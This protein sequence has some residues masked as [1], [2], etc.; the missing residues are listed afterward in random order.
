MRASSDAR[1]GDANHPQYP[2]CRRPFRQLIPNAIALAAGRQHL[3]TQGGLAEQGVAGQDAAR[4]SDATQQD[5]RDR[6]LRFR[7]VGRGCDRLVGE[8]DAV[9]MTE[10]AEGVDRATVLGE[11]KPAP[12]RFA[13][14][15][16]ALGGGLGRRRRRVRAEATGQRGRQGIAIEAAKQALQRRLARRAP[17]RKAERSEHARL[18]PR[19]PFGYRQDR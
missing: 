6:Q 8:D 19:A 7:L 13:V 14:D 17:V 1:R 3:L 4:P 12:L 2:A 18:L 9:V 16:H 10:R 11:A 15:R 5:G